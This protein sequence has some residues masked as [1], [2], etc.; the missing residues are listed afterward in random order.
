MVEFF[1]I[2]G[3]FF[4]SAT[5]FFL[6]PSATIYAGYGFYSTIIITT[7]GGIFGFLSFFFFGK[8]IKNWINRMSYRKAKVKSKFNYRNRIIVK[9]KMKYGLIGLA[10]LTPSL[11]GI[12]IGA[13]I[14]SNYFGKQKRTIP[15]FIS[16]IFIWSLLL[17]AITIQFKD[18]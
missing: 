9:I 4:F 2:A 7:L 13:L 11:I 17:T 3:L 6:A 15:I 12:P 18:A 10:L 14:A 1:K 5:K 8:W 16:S